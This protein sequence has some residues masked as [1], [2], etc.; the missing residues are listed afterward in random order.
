MKENLQIFL[1][2]T[3]LNGNAQALY[4]GFHQME[5]YIITFQIFIYLNMTYI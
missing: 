2:R 3:K 1:I 4:S 5:K